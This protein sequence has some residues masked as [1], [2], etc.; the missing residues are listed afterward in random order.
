MPK[1]FDKLIE[2]IFVNFEG[3]F[4]EKVFWIL[5]FLNEIRGL[6][7]D[8]YNTKIDKLNNII[9]N[10]SD[11]SSIIVNERQSRLINE[12]LTINDEVLS[13]MRLDIL[14]LELSPYKEKAKMIT[15]IPVSDGVLGFSKYS[16]LLADLIRN[17][18][19]RFAIGI[20][21]DWGTGKT[22]LMKI[23]KKKIEEYNIH[24]T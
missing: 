13:D 7:E 16:I 6:G 17:S 11:I 12:F 21:G 19:P 2:N 20:F 15:D 22:T 10:T 4:E 3:S 24:N 1:P 14:K 18:R 8:V 5:K 23:I 9:K